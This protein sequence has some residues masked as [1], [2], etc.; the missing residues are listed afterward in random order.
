MMTRLY[1]GHELPQ[2]WELTAKKWEQ[3]DPETEEY[4]YLDNQHNAGQTTDDQFEDDCQSWWCC[5][6]M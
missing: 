5:S 2:F 3:V 4:L 6:C 1:S